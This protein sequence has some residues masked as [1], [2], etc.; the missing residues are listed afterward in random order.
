MREP[1][2]TRMLYCRFVA[3]TDQHDYV[4][5]VP[6]GGGCYAQIPYRTGG[7]RLEIG[8]QQSGCVV[9]SIV[10][11]ELLHSL[12]FSH[13]QN[14]PDRDEYVDMHWDNIKAG[15]AGQFFIQSWVDSSPP[16]NTLCDETNQPAGNYHLFLI[17]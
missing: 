8:L 13:E 7:G 14:R 12:G 16:F 5:I 6:G 2:L 1:C 11:H 3:R 9:L 17:L 10:V 4:D 15:G